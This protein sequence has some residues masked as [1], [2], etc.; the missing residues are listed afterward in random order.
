[1]N[2]D[3]LRGYLKRV[4]SDLHQAQKRIGEFEAKSHEPIA[5]VG[6]GCRFPGD[7]RS[8]D[9]LWRLLSESR[10]TDSPFPGNRG[11]DVE[12]L[13]DP[14]PDAHGK[15]Y[16]VRGHF[17]HDADEFDADFFGI[18]PREARAMDPQQRL[19]LET[20][21]QALEHAGIVPGDLHGSST[22]VFT[23][24]AAVEYASLRRGGPES[25]DG[26]LLTGN[27]SSVASGRIA[28]TFGFEGPAVT[29]DTACSSSLVTVH[30][31][32]QALRSGECATAL[33]GGATVMPHA[34]VFVEFSRQRGLA[35]DGRCKPFAASADGTAWGEGV[36]MLVLER[37]SD[38]RRL[39]HRVLAVIRG[40]AVNQDGASNGLTAP[41]G[42]SQQRVIRAALANAELPESGIDA[43]EAHGTGTSL[44]DPIEAQALLAT[45]GRNRPAERPL[46]LGSLKSN[47]GHTQVAAGVAGVIK[48]VLAL[49]HG[50]LP[51]TL[52]VDE[53]SQHVDWSSGALALLTES[54]PW[55]ESDRPRRGAVSA[56][57]ISGTNAHVILEA[58]PGDPGDAA[59]TADD[60]ASAEDDAAGTE[61]GPAGAESGVPWLLSGK[62]ESALREQAVRLSAFVKERP[63]LDLAGAARALASTRTH[64]AYRAG[65]VSQGREELLAALD[66]LARGE[67]VAGLVEGAA[68]PDPGKTVFVFPGQGSQWAG[69]GVGLL[70][71]SPVFAASLRQCADALSAYVDWDL[72]D[73]LH[74][75]AGAPGFER[76]DVVQPALFALMVSLARVWESHGIRADAVIGHSQGEIAAAHIAGAL[77]LDDA[78]RIVCLRS[79][80]L[81]TLTGSGG[82]ASIPLSAEE[83]SARVADYPGLHVAAHNGPESTVISGDAGALT[84][85]VAACKNEGIRARTIDVDYASHSPHIENLNHIT[86]LL[87]GITPSPAEIPFYSTLTGTRLDTTQLT[88]DYWYR[89]LRHPVLLEQTLRLL[90]EDGHHTYIETSPHPVLTT[91]IQD[92]NPHTTVLGTL[93]RNDATPTRLLTTLTQAHTHGHTPTTWTT[94][95]DTTNHPHLDLPTYPFQ[96][97]RF[98]IAEPSAAS[99]TSALGLGAT[100]HALLGAVTELPDGSHLFTGGLSLRT[101]PWLAE[102]AVGGER[103]GTVLLPGTAFVELALHAGGE[104]GCARVEELTLDAPLVLPPLGSTQLQLTVGAPDEAGGRAV[105]FRSRAERADEDAPDG[106]GWTSHATGRLTPA[107][108]S[109]LEGTAS[110]AR[111]WPPPQAEEYDVDE[112]YAH[113][114]DL[115]YAYGPLFQGLSTAWRAADGTVYADVRLP[116]GAEADRD[117]FLLHP[118]LFDAALHPGALA[119]A[120]REGTSDGDPEGTSGGGRA[121]DAEADAL[122]LPYEWRGVTLHA[123]GAETLRLRMTRPSAGTL[124]LDLASGGVTEDGGEGGAAGAPVASVEALV[125][126]PVSVEQLVGSG[127]GRRSAGYRLEW[128]PMTAPGHGGVSPTA[129]GDYRAVIG[130]DR[131]VIGD[132]WAVIGSDWAL[133]GGGDRLTTSTSRAA[134][135]SASHP[136]SSH[137]ASA[138]RQAVGEEDGGGTAVY[139]DLAELRA[140]MV[141]RGAVYGTVL[142]PCSSFPNEGAATADSP[143]DGDAARAAHTLTRHALALL[144]DW[145]A[146]ENEAAP[147]SASESASESESVAQPVS[148]S[149]SEARLV[150]LTRRAVATTPDQPMVDPSAAALWGLVRSAQAENPGR[151]QLVDTDGTDASREALADAVATG[152]PQLALR[153]GSAY[154]PRLVR[155]A[156]PASTPAP[157]ATS[158]TSDASTTSDTPSDAAATPAALSPDGTVLIT[159]GTGTLGGLAARHL[160]TEHGVR[161]LL[162]TSRRG[163][164][165]PGARELEAELLA[166]GAHVTLAACDAADRDALAA[167]VASI[168]DQHPLTA[169]IHTAGVLDDATLT[170]LTP[171]QLTTVLQPKVDAA[172][173]LHQL[174]ADTDLD[175]FVLYSS[176]AGTLGNPG[177]ANYAA[178]NT[179]LDALA[180]HRH[181][182]GLP[183][184][185]LAW[186]LW[187]HSSGLTAHL[188]G[189]EQTRLA[190]GG[191]LPLSS[192]EGMA[193]FDGALGTLGSGGSDLG[194]S[195]V[196]LAK[197]DNKALRAEAEAGS[198]PPVLRGVVR[199]PVRRVTAG[200]GA[201]SWPERLAGLPEAQQEKLLLELVRGQVATVL[202]HAD[203]QG[204]ASDQAFQGLGFDSLTA[205][206]L[207]NRLNTATGL[208]LTATLVFDHPTPAALARHL[209]EQLAGGE[210]AVRGV[211]PRTGGGYAD[212]PIAI[213][214]MACRYPGGITSPD[215]L[216][217][218]VS[219]GREGIGGFPE[220]RGWDLES[221][222]DPD[223]EHSGTSYTRRGGF[224]HNAHHFDPDFFGMSPREALATD[225]QQRLLLETTWEALENARILPSSLR[226][227]RT[228]VYTGIMYNDY[229]GRIQ[230][231]PE[232]LEGYLGNGSAFSVAS[233][234]IAYTYGFEGP[235]VS[236][237]TACSSSLVALH[238]AA[239]ALRG[240]ECDMA[241]AG[242]VTVMATPGLFVEFSRQRGLSEDGRCKSFAATADGA[243]FSEGVGLLL[244]ERLSDARAKGHPVLAVVRGSAVN[245]DGASNGLTA[246]N[247]PS[248]QR[249]IRDALAGAGLSA[250]DVDAVEAHG[251]GT[252]L[253]DPIEAQ[254]LLATYGQERDPEKPL[255]LGSIK[256]N[257]GHTQAAAGVAGVIKMVQALRHGELP[258]TLHVDE[259]SP[260]VDWDSGAVT[261]LTRNQPWPQDERPGRAAVSSFGISGTNA[262]VI[263]EAAPAPE[264]NDAGG[265][266]VDV[267]PVLLSAKNQDALRGQ[268]AQLA[269]FLNERPEVEVAEIGRALAASRTHHTYRAGVVSEERGELLEA[270]SALAQGLPH[271][272]LV[273]GVASPDPGKTVFVFPGQGSQWAG[274][275]IGLLDSSPVF[276]ASLRQCADA[277]S[278]YVDW[279]LFDVLYERAGAP[280]FER[281]DVV[282]PALFALMVSL[283]RVWES[284]GI[285]ADAVIGHSQGEIAAAHIAGALSLDDAAR[286]VCLRS[287]ALVT[288]AGTG[289]MASIPLSAEKTAARLTPYPGL[290]VAAHN[291]P[292]ST[293]ISG[294][295]S[296]LAEMVAACQ[297]EGIRART[298]D[299]D[300]ASHSPHIENLNH[301]TQ[302]LEGIT[303][304]PAQIP[305]YSTLTGTQL[306]TTQL[307]ADYWYRNLRHPVLLEQTLRLL[308]E[309]GHHTYIETSPHPVLTT[310]T[311]DTNPHTTVLGTLRRNDATPTRLL[312]TLTQAHTHGHTPTTWTTTQ[313]TPLTL[314]LTPDLPTY[315]FQH[316][317]YWLTAPSAQDVA[318][319]GLDPAGHPLLSAVA[320]LP[321]GSALFTGSLSLATHPWLSE[322]VVHEAALLPGA[323]FADLALHVGAQSGCGRLEE[324]TLE[325]PFVLPEHGAL[326]LQVVLG[327]ADEEGRRALTVRSR[328]HTSGGDDALPWTAHA[329][330]TLA[331]T[332]ATVSTTAPV[333]AHAPAAWPPPQAQRLD[334]D[335]LYAQL[336]DHGLV[337]GPLFQGL[338][339]AWRQ[340]GTVYAEISLPDGTDTALYGIHP[341]LLDAALHTAFLANGTDG[342]LSN[343]TDGL[344]SDGVLL[345]FSWGE[346]T[347]HSGCATTLR[348]QL[349]VTEE[350]TLALAVSDP[351]GSPVLTVGSLTTRPVTPE[352]LAHATAPRSLLHHLTWRP[353]ALPD[354]PEPVSSDS[355]GT[356]WAALGHDLAVSGPDWLA[357]LPAYDEVGTLH[358]ALADGTLPAPEAV[359]APC[360]SR[361]LE[362]PGDTSTDGLRALTEQVEGAEQTTQAERAP[363]DHAADATHALTEH[364]LRLVQD[365]LAHDEIPVP[366]EAATGEAAT[367]EAATREAASGLAADP[368]EAADPGIATDP[369]MATEP[370]RL[371][372]LTRGAVAAAPEESP[373]DLPASAVW[374]LVRSAQS[375][376]PGRIQLIDVD[377]TEASFAALP[378]LVASGEPQLAVRAGRACVPRVTR[379]TGRP[380]ADEAGFA[381]APA[382]ALAGTV[383]VTGGTGTLGGLTARHLVT[384][385]GARHLLLTSRR[386]PDAPGAR[387]LETELTALGAHVT[388]AACDAA[389]RDALAALV[390]SIPDQHPLTAVIHTA[391]VLDDA[392]L[393]SLTPEQLTTVL[394]P[395]VDAAW[396]LH[397]LTADADLDAF[398]LYSSAAGTLGSPGQANYAAAN[399]FLDALAHQRRAQGLPA[400]SVAWGLWEQ[401][402]GLTGSLD[403]SEIS[404]MTRGGLT[405][406]ATRDAL[407]ALDEAMVCAAP[408]AVGAGFHAPSLRAQAESG[409]LPPVLRELVRVPVRRAAGGGAGQGAG[410]W[411]QRLSG[412]DEAERESTVLE[413]V[414]S[415]TAAVL[416]HAEARNVAAD[417]AFQD[418]GFD[419]LTAVELRNRLNTATGL[420]LTAT[421]VFDHPTP[422]ALAQ[423]LLTQLTG[424][425]APRK[426]ALT[427]RATSTD[428]PIAIVGMAC[429]YPGGITSPDDLWRLVSEGRE[430]IGGFPEE[431]GWDLATLYDPDPEHPGTSYTRRGGFLHNAHHFDPDFFGMSPREA[432]A[433]DPQQRLLLETTWEA[434]ENAGI[435]PSSLRGSRTGV[436]TGIMY[437]DY[438]GRL[439]HHIPQEFEGYIGNG[440]SGGVVSGRV[441]YTFGFE[442]PAVTVD[443]ACSSSLVAL[444]MAAQAL[445]GGECD[446]ALAGGATVMATPTTFI[447][448]SRQR[449]LSEDGRC[450]SFAAAADGTGFSEGVGLLLV[451]RLSDAQAKGH[452]VLAV[453]RG[454][455]INQDGA[456][457]GLTA[458]NG[459]SQQRVIHTALAAAELTPAD[460]D[461]V[462]AHGT[463]TTLGDPIE[464]QALLATYGQERPEE[465][466]LWL[467]SIKSN[468]GH[469]QAAAGVAGVIKM[470]QALR[471]GELPRT[472][473]ADEPSPHVDWSSGAVS[474]LTQNQPWP[475]KEQPRRAAV[476]SFGISGTNAHVILEAAQDTPVE[477]HPETPNLPLLLSAKNQD[478]L[479][480]Q[481]AQLATF[482]NERPEARI[483]EIGRA[484]ATTRTQH[485]HRAGVVADGYDEALA[486]LHSLARGE[487]SPAVVQGVASEAGKIAFVFAGQG[488]QRAGMGAGLY[489]THPA[490]AHALDEVCAHFDPHLQHPLRDIMFA[491]EDDAL[492]PLLH[493]TQYT[494]PALFALG[495][496]LHHLYLHHGIKPHY[497]AGHSIG[498]LTA[499][500]AAGI[501]TLTDATTLVATRARLLQNLPPGGAMLTLH[502]TEKD[503]LETLDPQRVSLAA[504]NAPTSTVIS[505]DEQAI[506]ELATLWTERGHKTKRLHV[507]HAFHSHLMQPALEEF[508]RTAAQLTYHEPH[509]PIISNTT[510][511]LATTTQLRDPDYWTQ[512]IRQPVR[513]ADTTTTLHTHHV[514]THLELGPD[515]TLTTLNHHNLDTTPNP[516]TLLPTL[517]PHQPEPTTLTHTLTTLH[518]HGHTPTTWTTTQD[519]TPTTTPNLPTYPFQHQP[520]WLHSPRPTSGVASAGLQASGHPL[521][522]AGT[523]L[524]DGSHLFTGS[525]SLAAHPWLADHAVYGT[526]LLPGAALLDLALHAA[527]HTGSAHVRELT[528]HAPLALPEQGAVQVQVHLG[529]AAVEEDGARTLAVHSRPDPAPG[530]EDDLPWTRHAQGTLVTASDRAATP[531]ATPSN[532]PPTG[533]DPVEPEALYEQFAADG[534]D[535]GPAFRGLTAAWRDGD[536]IYADIA[537]PEALTSNTATS[538]A[539]TPAHVIHPA[540][541]DAALHPLTLLTSSHPTPEHPTAREDGA[542]R[543]PYEW[544]EVTAHTAGAGAGAVTAL[545]AHLRR[546][547]DGAASVVLTDPEGEP[548]LSG[549]LVVR[550]MRPEQ[551]RAGLGG[552]RNT[553]YELNWVPV[554]EP[555]QEDGGRL[556]LLGEGPAVDGAAAAYA[557]LMALARALEEDGEPVPGTVVVGHRPGEQPQTPQSERAPHD[558][559]PTEPDTYGVVHTY[560]TLLQQ[561]LADEQF[562]E[563]RLAIVTEGAVA[564]ERGEEVPSLASAAVWGLLRSAQS[565]N[566][567]RF[568]LVDTDGL[569]ASRAALPTALNCGEPQVALR[570]GVVHV[571]RLAP[572]A[573]A[574]TD[575][576]TSGG[577]GAGAGGGAEAEATDG[578]GHSSS[579]R[580]SIDPLDPAGTVLVTGGTGAL[581]RLVARHLVA[582]HGVRH[583]VLASRSGAAAEGAEELRAELATAGAEVRMAACDVADAEALGALLADVPAAHPL[584][585][586]FHTAG[587]LDDATVGSLTSEQLRSV[588]RPKADAAWNLHA[589]TAKADLAA[590]VL[591]SSAAGTLG[592][593]GQANYAA[594]NTFLDALAHHRQAQ[595]LPALSLAWGPWEQ[596]AD[597]MAATLTGADE[598]RM[599]RNGLAPLPSEE[600]LSLLDAAL[601]LPG[602]ATLVPVRLRLPAL[603]ALAG[604]G[605][606]PPVLRGL[607]RTPAPSMGGTLRGGGA[608]GLRQSLLGRLKDHGEA[609]RDVV[610]LEFVRS[611]IGSVLGHGSPD[612]VDPDQGLMAMGFDSLTAVE[613]RNRLKA[614]TELRLPATLVFDYPTPSALARYLRE[615]LEPQLPHPGGAGKGDGDTDA[616]EIRRAL[617]SIPVERLREA[618]LIEPLLRLADPGQ[619]AKDGGA[620]ADGADDADGGGD[621]QERVDTIREADVADLIAI[622]LSGSGTNNGTNDES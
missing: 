169:V 393:T 115:G 369:G 66:A 581:G 315:P 367:G 97:Q 32:V 70:D 335:D 56:F 209:R 23:G 459:P 554:A 158:A 139:A 312:T 274:M 235:A 330:G 40:S 20:S 290:Y 106:D 319:A 241:V 295:A 232:E 62:S 277:L 517:H 424:T 520:Y 609:E 150:L 332:P 538:D 531:V 410:G 95:Q 591:F 496:A 537:L 294:D 68:S 204:V 55:P 190:R 567:G 429:R 448:F 86:Q 134:S 119:G 515:T 183:A 72:F 200:G 560:L 388:L 532:W 272:A 563:A 415:H 144:Q 193:L 282:Q 24:A 455:A 268:A 198:L 394:Q 452:P 136:A 397:E 53:P 439:S 160:V 219:E 413:L 416:G 227:S 536:N 506:Q 126:R 174:T 111:V 156:L 430:G 552:R 325:A 602:R 544:T 549:T 534:L 313:D 507:S 570:D 406:L 619:A 328:P 412:M 395:K 225:P 253:G 299:V 545:R 213:V 39:G 120:G 419:S 164:D 124:T 468:L 608:G 390:A 218:L 177:Q 400:T 96:P 220:G 229:G 380:A 431:R 34:G 5:I 461:A 371:V 498:E 519:P 518:T 402:S 433:T 238:M 513:W 49:R 263:L 216:W 349:S 438:G 231:A 79:Q 121:S 437:N 146:L 492:A 587:V 571:P 385:H 607:V 236:V 244:V 471:H 265:A 4:T 375:E 592:G 8:P 584:T 259:P 247:G 267:V 184:T 308:H 310:P 13:Y 199:T 445:R 48:M 230:R 109:A 223:P 131:A 61:E 403:G 551:L 370:A 41:N 398:V 222:Y 73:V 249:V 457:N 2:E 480:G 528:L 559:L 237:D 598:R 26:Y 409:T 15:T 323:A 264:Q 138:S 553:L 509:T 597:G 456:S 202:G 579:Y 345:P 254:A 593:P 167:L 574:G 145:L 50:V 622:A 154:V 417:Q 270:L 565:E 46:W 318:A 344:L 365:W 248:Q 197:F 601:R 535:Y 582:A 527:A 191:V 22:G 88:A 422:T 266:P 484:L 348:A 425:I 195:A 210:K 494:Q 269:A 499:A 239:Q 311:Q 142:V 92:T 149:A 63:E 84:E 444:H 261:L 51:S 314:D 128:A 217:R 208:R 382:L 360:V 129:G 289:G 9:D 329:T 620:G 59:A 600:C 107:E 423:H 392:T 188:E 514:T 558:L 118:A 352:Q 255:W 275:G 605:L 458:P 234:R 178:A 172:W 478:A 354:G 440:S 374:G 78:A 135:A 466:P 568:T 614:A 36:G 427:P 342:L 454:S 475:E 502:A 481:A 362:A 373:L 586:V 546:T 37:L 162:L 340:G 125:T 6:M 377:G 488:S 233:G 297:S 157:S 356:R 615:E 346:V 33:A 28:Y 31:A 401:G 516:P 621:G 44:G 80:A 153:A 133:I 436:Y 105:H 355:G 485:A 306:D 447:E 469:T 166:H 612:A 21:W 503:V 580:D 588:L 302:L 58:V 110:W 495:T 99:D 595:G 52:H 512:H 611:Q 201:S 387:E 320:E 347:L 280:G 523:Q 408:T 132:D 604:E 510:G 180:H 252:T 336:A 470:V 16:A 179:F 407:R 116:E 1:M 301:I 327:A 564:A 240:G 87:E 572:A 108:S 361:L 276:A 599:A 284:H 194:D 91:P 418:L 505:G 192:E 357:V 271:A 405:P 472:L 101:H 205:V 324:L 487:E 396:N 161:H 151:I 196:V 214:G 542:V 522:G 113:L 90:N 404:R 38:A 69:M 557:D 589:L 215:D 281:V 67:S 262:H 224:L 152:E 511:D 85:M 428:E 321:D 533:A 473:H 137:P 7:V 465:R 351:E 426:V 60:D 285:R 17:L 363:S 435:L 594:A 529:P 260:H 353:F 186:G 226:G 54:R 76:V 278:T 127:R 175:A 446:M 258:R 338:R 477:E 539:L 547:P 283:A 526:P 228:G 379:A 376:H 378:A 339:A 168:P 590:F 596:S 25:T 18:S 441:S 525:L 521:L 81:V 543:V 114:T 94:T 221:L 77:S 414:R 479:R 250:A 165:A 143:G 279:D 421:L 556:V 291:G 35:P 206:E 246:P 569:P 450:K 483:A 45:Y 14:D 298:I 74:E 326:R 366:S 317:P 610:L 170:S 103:G 163:P 304:R 273:E 585:G 386:G 331:A 212:E 296:A 575:G 83:T 555:A 89:N 147:G 583:L 530:D 316:Q 65:V 185:S 372:L 257:L 300:Y 27:L 309:D 10:T 117:G 57:G 462:E 303:P 333:P 307:T 578:D 476:S 93:R 489:N 613:L 490:F 508:H 122:R 493:Q 203:P 211:V 391:G 245:Q 411:A 524:P 43:V 497:L 460:I 577:A 364:A 98:W 442:G 3:K 449:G 603:R 562:V 104:L 486:A 64:H 140:A 548:V 482:L 181:T 334:T 82:M 242:G 305:F 358:E 501:L 432:L 243:G 322:H 287:Q 189:G 359:L 293:V 19:L 463:G 207:R 148:S 130:D 561:W 573:G 540:L 141:E 451:E 453:L 47:I 100:G 171:E 155:V 500:H 112:L 616:E 251:T 550:E 102:H 11:W 182:Q 491:P 29:V 381:P 617:G 384:E 443:T 187:A 383:L 75:R 288:L 30:M 350:G 606:L 420:R 504:V 368:E 541:L 173:N 42:P 576:G 159:G 389:D 399:A 337:Y 467:G 464:A 71:S 123:S 286:V 176:A 256:S 12:G 341:A 566:P 434:L 618:G 292:E 343:G 474:L